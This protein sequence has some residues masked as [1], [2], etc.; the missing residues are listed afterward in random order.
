MVS[1]HFPFPYFVQCFKS[2]FI[3]YFHVVWAAIHCLVGDVRS[4]IWCQIH[5]IR[6]WIVY[7]KIIKIIISLKI[8]HRFCMCQYLY[9][10]M[11]IMLLM[12]KCLHCKMPNMQYHNYIGVRLATNAYSYHMPT[13]EDQVHNLSG[14][15]NSCYK[16]EFKA[17]Y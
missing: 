17:Y 16:I 12:W 4:E 14:T 7:W 11:E 10:Q 15:S 3:P 8:C 2:L 5:K 13:L 9:N 1:F 6:E